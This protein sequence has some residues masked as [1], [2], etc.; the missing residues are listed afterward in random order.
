[1]AVTDH[2]GFRYIDPDEEISEFPGFWDYETDK[3][4]DAIHDAATNDVDIDRLPNLPASQINSGEFADARIPDSIAR[5]ADVDEKTGAIDNRIDLNDDK[6]SRYN[7]RISDLETSDEENEDTFE[8]LKSRLT[9]LEHG[10]GG[11]DG[12][13]D[14]GVREVNDLFPGAIMYHPTNSLCTISRFGPMVTLTLAAF[15]FD[16]D[17]NVNI[18][19]IPEGFRPPSTIRFQA[20]SQGREPIQL[21]VRG[22]TYDV[23]AYDVPEDANGYTA[24]IVYRT[25]DDVPSELPGNEQ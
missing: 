9:E 17:G 20:L 5:T 19:D 2:Y 11:G 14:S 10:G 25:G 21:A 4:D 16:D 3:I 22:G 6:L 24:H 12:V 13:F 18:G 15:N 8:D 1:M 23:Y 7:S